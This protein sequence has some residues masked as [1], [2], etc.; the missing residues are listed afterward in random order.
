MI[1]NHFLCK[2]WV[3]HPIDSQPFINGWPQ[4]VPGEGLQPFSAVGERL[5]T[6]FPTFLMATVSLVS[7]IC[8][9]Y[10]DNLDIFILGISGWLIR[11]PRKGEYIYIYINILYVIIYICHDPY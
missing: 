9:E 7:T 1:S 8:A 5:E 11:I 10:L 6:N 3:H 4:G 2:D